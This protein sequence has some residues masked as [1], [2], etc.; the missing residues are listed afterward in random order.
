MSTILT[1][2][3]DLFHIHKWT[4]YSDPEITKLHYTDDWGRTTGYGAEYRQYK[5]CLDCGKITWK[6]V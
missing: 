3:R 4:K 5:Q 6:R 1:F 2:L